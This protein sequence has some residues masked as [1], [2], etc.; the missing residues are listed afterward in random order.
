MKPP[1][2]VMSA[3]DEYK[4]AED[5]VGAFL[6]EF[7]ELKDYMTVSVSDLYEAF[8]ENSDFY[9]KKKDFNDYL[10]K[11]GYKKE[12]LTSGYQKGRFI[13]KGIGLCGNSEGEDARPY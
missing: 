8:K 4:S 7:C 6:E 5:G 9:M 3:T 2:I 1:D 13:W 11:H 10:E 12:R